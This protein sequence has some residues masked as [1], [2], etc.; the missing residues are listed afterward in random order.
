MN[1]PIGLKLDKKA[2]LHW[3]QKQERRYEL[4]DGQ[5]TKHP[6]G[7]KR[8]AW[9]IGAFVTLFRTELDLSIWCVGPTDIAIRLRLSD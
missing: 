1:A 5:V 9:I 6:G 3:V 2:F 7:T 4:K 8:H